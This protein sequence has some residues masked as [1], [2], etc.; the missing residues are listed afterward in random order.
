MLQFDLFLLPID[1]CVICVAAYWLKQLAEHK[2][3][4]F[5]VSDDADGDSEADGPRRKLPVIA[6]R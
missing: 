3:I 5:G 2:I 6:T 4:L 1:C